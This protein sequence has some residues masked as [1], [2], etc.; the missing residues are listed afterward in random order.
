MKKMGK[1]WLM[2][3]MLFSRDVPEQVVAN[4]CQI[5]FGPNVK[6]IHKTRTGH[7]LVLFKEPMTTTSHVWPAVPLASSEGGFLTGTAYEWLLRP[8]RQIKHLSGRKQK[9]VMPRLKH[10]VL[11]A[12]RLSNTLVV[13]II[14]RQ[15]YTA[16]GGRL[17]PISL[18]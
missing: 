17:K 15:P 14:S 8:D 11:W 13:D 2:D 18:S 1:L 6:A 4:T 9:G 3:A 10:R 5:V 16:Q 7:V 12:E